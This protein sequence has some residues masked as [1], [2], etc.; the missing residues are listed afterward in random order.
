MTGRAK[1]DPEGRK[2]TII[3]ATAQLIAEVG[4]AGVNHRKIAEKAGVPLG[5]TTQYF[6]SREDLIRAA[7]ENLAVQFDQ[8]LDGLAQDLS[9]SGDP[10]RTVARHF[11]SYADE[12][13]RSRAATAF[14]LAD[15]QSP[16]M[17]YL[18]RHWYER[19]TAVLRDRFGERFARAAGTFSYGLFVH[20]AQNDPLPSE[21]EI[22][23]ILERLTTPE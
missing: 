5:A 3:T 6:L 10:V 1:R 9:E 15:L 7:L 13:E 11:L 16:G 4:V 14:F 19:Q 2:Q 21:D 23:W 22:V 20:Y 17:E 8:D 12:D 18:T